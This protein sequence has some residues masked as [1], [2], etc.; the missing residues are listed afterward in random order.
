MVAIS[1]VSPCIGYW[2]AGAAA[3]GVAP[4]N[5]G[6]GSGT[7]QKLLLVSYSVFLVPRMS[8]GDRFKFALWGGD[9][10]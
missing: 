1:S 10:G 6:S 5:L 7:R 2:G 9:R 8:V 3:F 4:A